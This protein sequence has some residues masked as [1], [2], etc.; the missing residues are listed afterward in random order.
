MKQLVKITDLINKT[1]SK[2][3]KSNDELYIKFMD[4]SFVVFEINNNTEGF[5]Y[6]K[7]SI[8]IS[9]YIRDNTYHELVELG[10]ITKKDFTD[11]VLQEDNKQK[12]NQ[13]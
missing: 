6:D 5:G 10:L 9:D 3:I 11:A 2:T 13:S 1:I 8:E 7:K 4:D 12:K